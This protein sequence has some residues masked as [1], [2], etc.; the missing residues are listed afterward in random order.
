M[1]LTGL[2]PM[3]EFALPAMA[4]V[5]LMPLVV[6][7]GY[8][9]AW[10]AFG[11]VSLLSAILAPNKECALYYIALLGFYPIVKSLIDRIKSGAV[12]WVIKFLVFNVSAAAIGLSAMFVFS[13]PGYKE[14]LEEAWWMLAGGWLF[15]NFAFLVYDI[16]LTQLITAYLRWFRPKYIFKIFK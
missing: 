14:M 11:A 10:M 4:G 7:S 9:P 5:F 2:I 15:M 6:E 12:R 3:A 1:L 13:F 16:A 8:K